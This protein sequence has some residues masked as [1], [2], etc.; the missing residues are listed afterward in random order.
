MDAEGVDD[1]AAAQCHRRPQVKCPAGVEDRHQ[2]VW[3]RRVGGSRLE[4][5]N[6]VLVA[7]GVQIAPCCFGMQRGCRIRK[8]LAQHCLKTCRQQVR[9]GRIGPGDVRFELL[10]DC[11]LIVDAFLGRFRVVRQPGIAGRLA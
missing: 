9:L 11:G 1:D 5:H 2:Q 7:I 4:V 8:R 3:L 6:E 10:L